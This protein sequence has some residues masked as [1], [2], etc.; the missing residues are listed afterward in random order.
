MNEIGEQAQKQGHG[1]SFVIGILQRALQLES[2]MQR[3]QQ[4][5]ED[6]GQTQQS[7]LRKGAEVFAVGIA[8]VG[9][10]GADGSSEI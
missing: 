10:V 6:S 9:V 8:E 5:R 1:H 7:L 4:Q 3:S 2:E